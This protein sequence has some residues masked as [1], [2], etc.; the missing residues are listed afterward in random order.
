[1]LFTKAVLDGIAAGRI[2]VAYRRW[3]RPRAVVGGRQR[4]RV[5][6]LAI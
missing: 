2:T 4:T 3:D 1:V 6:V 5:G